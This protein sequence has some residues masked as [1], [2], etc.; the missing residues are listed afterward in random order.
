MIDQSSGA[1]VDLKNACLSLGC[2]RVDKEHLNATESVF[3]TSQVSR[4]F[5]GSTDKERQLPSH[6][7]LTHLAGSANT[8]SA[9]CIELRSFQMLKS[10]VI[11]IDLVACIQLD[12]LKSMPPNCVLHPI[13]NSFPVELFSDNVVVFGNPVK[14]VPSLDA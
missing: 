10:D 4:R 5:G 6:L 3:C 11:F 2:A 8:P 9:F 12:N 14:C 7:P 1:L 13:R